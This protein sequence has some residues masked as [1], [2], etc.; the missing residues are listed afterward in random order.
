MLEKC[1]VIEVYLLDTVFGFFFSFHCEAKILQISIIA[2]P[3][4]DH[5]SPVSG[6]HRFTPIQV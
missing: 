2:N 1:T 6:R 5:I 3:E 4:Y